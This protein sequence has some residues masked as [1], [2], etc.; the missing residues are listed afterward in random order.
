MLLKKT[1]FKLFDLPFLAMKEV[2]KEMGFREVLAF[3]LISPRCKKIIQTCRL[4]LSRVE[5]NVP[6]YRTEINVIDWNL[7][8]SWIKVLTPDFTE[9]EDV[10][11]NYCDLFSNRFFVFWRDDLTKLINLIS[12][13]YQPFECG[14]EG[15]PEIIM[16]RLPLI[17]NVKYT[18]LYGVNDAEVIDKFF[19]TYPNQKSTR[20]ARTIEGN[21]KPD[22]KFYEVGEMELDNSRFVTTTFLRNFKGH[23]LM[24]KN[25]KCYD[26]TIIR[27]IR[28]WIS[29]EDHLNIG[30]VLIL[31]KFMEFNTENIMVEFETMKLRRFL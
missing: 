27:F 9:T 19:D 4:K 17:E 13:L 7:G 5:Y 22:S 12:S 20:I 14:I 3:S 30:A 1:L 25:S 29:G 10:E 15:N 2:I 26:S 11:P 21:L 28:K 6:G 31:N 24:I 16:K 8:E 18:C 23:H